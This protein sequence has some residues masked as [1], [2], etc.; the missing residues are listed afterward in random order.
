[1]RKV[2]FRTFSI[3]IVLYQ[4]NMISKKKKIRDTF[5][6]TLNAGTPRSQ[7]RI[8]M[9]FVSHHQIANNINL[10]DLSFSNFIII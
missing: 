3:I 4:Q 9:F 6:S 10:T 8:D 7:P 2:V 1:M 5:F